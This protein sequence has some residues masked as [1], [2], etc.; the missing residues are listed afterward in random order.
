[1]AFDIGQILQGMTAN[2]EQ[3]IGQISQQADAMAGSTAKMESLLQENLLEGQKVVEQATQTAALKAERDFKIQSAQERAAAVVGLN[4]DDLENELVRSMREYNAAEDERKMARTKYDQLASTSLLSN[5]IGYIMAQLELPA[6]SAEHNALLAKREAAADNIETRQQLLQAHKSAM[7][8]NTA[9]MTK[10]IAAQ[11]ASQEAAAARLRLREAEAANISKI[12]GQKLQEYQH[13]NSIFAIQDAAFAKQLQVAQFQMNLEDRQEARKERAAAAAARM[14]DKQTEEEELAEFD[15]QL[16]RV[17]Q[18][19][20]L[21]TPMTVEL[22][23]KIPDPK[24]R[25]AW[26]EA[27]TTGQI[28]SDI[29]DTL[30]FI[31]TSGNMAALNQNNPGVGYAARNFS[32][33]LGQY[34]STIDRQAKASGTPIKKLEELNRLATES[35]SKAIVMSA[36]DPNSAQNL[37]APQWNETFNPY[38]AQYKTLLDEVDKGPLAALSNN[39]VVKAA[40]SVL[41]LAD[42]NNPNLDTRSEQRMLQLVGEMVKNKDIGLDE[43]AQQI[44][45]FYGLSAEK[46]RKL[47]QY[48]LFNLP[49]QTRYMATIP[50]TDMWGQTVNVD[51]MN[52]ASVKRALAKQAV[53]KKNVQWLGGFSTVN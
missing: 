25:Q 8:V 20:G 24:R 14:K 7:V 18:F 13:R 2:T 34:A 48:D 38:R 22:W 42:P 3:R 31:N 32:T 35:Y 15:A 12:A 41:P 4:E 19:V 9:D 36:S 52:A 44:T 47:F 10:E 37:T 23:K 30:Q 50:A 21:A 53:T 5:P 51:L 33:A 46:N 26:L 40:K 39:V 29:A 17:S 11:V 49:A 43:A 1:M 6:A 45:Q 28:G 27:A 16:Q